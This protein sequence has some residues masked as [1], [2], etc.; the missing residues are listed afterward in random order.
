LKQARL[1]QQQL[2]NELSELNEQCGEPRKVSSNTLSL[3]KEIGGDSEDEEEFQVLN[4]DD[5]KQLQDNFNKELVRHL[6]KPN[7]ITML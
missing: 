3:G 2:E 5:S 7:H 4:E 6:R 1:Q